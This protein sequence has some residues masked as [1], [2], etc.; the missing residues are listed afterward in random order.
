MFFLE[1]AISG[2]IGNDYESVT[3]ASSEAYARWM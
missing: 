1:S 3:S 2:Q